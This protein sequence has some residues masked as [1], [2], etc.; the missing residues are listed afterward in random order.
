M[1]QTAAAWMMLE[2]IMGLANGS[3]PVHVQGLFSSIASQPSWSLSSLSPAS[4]SSALAQLRREQSSFFAASASS[5]ALPTSPL[6]VL[7]L[8]S[9]R[10][11]LT[12]TVQ[13]HLLLQSSL[14]S[15]QEAIPKIREIQDERLLQHGG[16]VQRLN[17]PEASMERNALQSTPFEGVSASADAIEQKMLEGILQGSL[18]EE[19]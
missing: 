12:P 7:P 17:H 9:T 2:D 16:G 19:Q 1:V 18:A 13:H 11:V 15:H 10:T 4:L 14:K 5:V 8:S 3:G 6:S